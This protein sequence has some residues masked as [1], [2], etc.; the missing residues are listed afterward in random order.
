MK[1]DYLIN[2][3]NVMETPDTGVETEEKRLKNGVERQWMTCHDFV[4]ALV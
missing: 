2:G 3:W 4:Y 1:D